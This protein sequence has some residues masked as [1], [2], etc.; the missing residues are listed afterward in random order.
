[1]S[2]RGAVLPRAERYFRTRCARRLPQFLPFGV[3]GPA[4]D[5]MPDS[6][7][8]ME[9]SVGRRLYGHVCGLM[10]QR[11][12]TGKA[13]GARLAA[14]EADLGEPGAEALTAAIRYSERRSVWG[15]PLALGDRSLGIPPPD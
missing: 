5:Q 10:R 14:V 8:P 4:V 7:H 12:A 2:P 1:M 6:A 9:S 15:L 13:P 11:R 3:I